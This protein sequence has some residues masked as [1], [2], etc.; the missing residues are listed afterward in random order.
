[1]TSN[2]YQQKYGLYIDGVGFFMKF[3]GTHVAEGNKFCTRVDHAAKFTTLENVT[4][5][6]SVYIA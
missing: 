1:M 4:D 6:F 2:K 3:N 5:L